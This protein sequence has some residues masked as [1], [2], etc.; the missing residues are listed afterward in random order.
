M[1]D[2]IQPTRSEPIFI[3][4]ETT[5]AQ[6]LR[7]TIRWAEY[8]DSLGGGV[9]NVEVASEAQLAGLEAEIRKNEGQL[10]EADRQAREVE[11][12]TVNLNRALAVISEL[13]KRVKELEALV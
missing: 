11:Q 1:T 4:S 12:L 3:E 9:N 2:I 6:D 5:N 13:S 8:L 7:F 10:H